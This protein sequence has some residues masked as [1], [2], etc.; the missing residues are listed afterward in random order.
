[1]EQEE[2][3]LD[4]KFRRLTMCQIFYYGILRKLTKFPKKPKPIEIMRNIL[5]ESASCDHVY[6][7]VDLRLKLEIEMEKSDP[8]VYYNINRYCNNPSP[9]DYEVCKRV[10]V[11][12]YYFTLIH[13]HQ[14]VEA[15]KYQ[16]GQW[17]FNHAKKAE[18][19]KEK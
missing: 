5:H 4:R 3:P 6:N 10:L 2:S 11:Q 15:A 16:S 7:M 12:D 19:K 13:I 14:A 17:L 9:S 1:M 18:E 8:S